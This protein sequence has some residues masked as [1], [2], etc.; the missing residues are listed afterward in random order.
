MAPQR[1]DAEGDGGG[2]GAGGQH[3]ADP[4]VGVHPGRLHERHPG[5]AEQAVRDHHRDLGD[6]LGVQRADAVAGAVGDAAA[7]RASKTTG[8]LGRFF[9]WFNRGFDDGDARLRER[10][11]RPGAQ[12]GGRRRSCSLASRRA[13]VLLGRRLPTSFVPEEDYGYFLLNVQLPPAAS[14]ERTDAVCRKI[15]DLLRAHRRRRQ[16]QHDRRLQPAVAR[17]RRATTASTSSASSRGT[18]GRA[19]TSRRARSSTGSTASCAQVVPEATAFAVMPPSI[20]GLG[21][22]GGFSFWLQDRSGGSLEFLEPERA[23]V[24]RRRAQAAGAGRR[25]VA[26]HGGGAA[27]LRRRRSRQGAEAGRRARRRLPDDAGV[28]RR[29]LRQPVQPLRP[30]VARVP[31]GRRRGRARA[32]RT[33]ASSTCATTTARWCRSR[34]SR[35]PSRR[36]DRST[37]TASTST[38]PRRSPARAAP[39]YSSGQALDALEEVA[40]QTLPREIS[41][42]WSDLS[43]Q[44]TKARA[45]SG[46]LF[47]L[48]I[49]VRVPDPRGALREL[50]AAVLGAAVGAGRGVRRVRSA[51][52]CAASTST[53]TR[54]SAWS[55]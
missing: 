39:G 53:S 51:C 41:Y 38:A 30:A 8:L 29:P 25:D 3:R 5:T 14:L 36:S 27:A 7:S 24:P 34:R 19:P 1:R 21:T 16:L 33:S 15:D 6:D 54:R 44:E 52:S 28:S 50:V 17:H 10:Q 47:A 2:V 31:A 46:G 13:A 32:R 22:Q 43:Y 35:R 49:A 18:S 37:P 11:P 40:Q 48:S 9:A 12:G 26:V 55:C 4:R 45:A 23:E 42:D 20:P